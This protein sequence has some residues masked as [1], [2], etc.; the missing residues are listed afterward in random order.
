[1]GFKIRMNG[2]IVAH[3]IDNDG[4]I[5]QNE[6]IDNDGTQDIVETTEMKEALDALNKDDIDNKGN[7]AMDL[8]SRLHYMEISAMLGLDSLSGY[9]MV[10]KKAKII[11]E[12][13]KRMSVSLDGLGRREIVAVTTGGGDNENGQAGFGKKLFQGLFG[14]KKKEDDAQ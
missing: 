7:S 5:E 13:K 8:R 2:D 6:I 4:S 1:M 10:N 9:H 12:K 11:T 3:D 14:T